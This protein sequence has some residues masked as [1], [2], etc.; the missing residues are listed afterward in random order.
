[1]VALHVANVTDLRAFHTP[2]YFQGG[3][4]LVGDD[5][6]LIGADYPARS[7]RYLDKGAI[8]PEEEGWSRGKLYERILQLYGAN[9]DFRRRLIP[10]GSSLPVLGQQTRTFCKG[11]KV[12]TEI[13]NM[14]NSRDELATVQP[15]FHIDMFLTLLGRPGPRN[16]YRVAVGDPAMA[17]EII[18]KEL[19]EY[20]L[21]DFA[22]PEVFDDIA[23]T[24]ARQHD[25][26]VVRTPL[27]LVYSDD[28]ARL[29]RRWYFATSNN[30]LVQFDREKPQNNIIWMPTYGYKPWEELKL[31]DTKTKEIYEGLGFKV[32]T[33]TNFHPFAENLGAMHCIKKYLRRG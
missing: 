20:E 23:R 12:W 17:A 22:M 27:P 1:M 19:P 9:L 28:E 2:L 14:G 5:F 8:I 13:S 25:F 6:F 16:K 10:I 26:E 18:K 11:G 21:P 15:L 3:N 31:T 33:L 24:L 32:R 4:V 29:E 30:C 7:L